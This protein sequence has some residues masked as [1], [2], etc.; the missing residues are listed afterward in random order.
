MVA[1][2]LAE[3]GR[4]RKLSQPEGGRDRVFFWFQILTCATN[5]WYKEMRTGQVCHH[6][7]GPNA[8]HGEIMASAVREAIRTRARMESE[9]V[10][11]QH[12]EAGDFTVS[13]T[14]GRLRRAKVAHDEERWCQGLGTGLRGHCYMYPA[15]VRDRLTWSA[16]SIEGRAQQARSQRGSQEGDNVDCRWGRHSRHVA[17]RPPLWKLWGRR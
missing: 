14:F 7:P 11:D 6:L 17:V 1:G 2:R 8:N 4:E 9:N 16:G 5:N 13:L 15:W 3:F 12:L 10:C